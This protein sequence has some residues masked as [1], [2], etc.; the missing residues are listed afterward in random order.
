MQRRANP[1]RRTNSHC[2]FPHPYEVVNTYAW[3]DHIIQLTGALTLQW[4]TILK[5]NIMIFI[6]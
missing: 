3:P 2:L 6:R 4:Q 5:L 1:R